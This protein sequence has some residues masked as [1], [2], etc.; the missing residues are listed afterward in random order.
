MRSLA[1]RVRRFSG[2]NPAA[3]IVSHANAVGAA[4]YLAEHLTRLFGIS[5]IPIVDA[6]IVL[7]A[8]VGPGSVAVSVRR[9]ARPLSVGAR[10]E[11]PHAMQTP[12]AHPGS[13]R[14]GGFLRR[15]RG[16][17]RVARKSMRLPAR[18]GR[19]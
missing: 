11:T 18:A 15:A 16:L 13:R 12:A 14:P 8:H 6:S 9:A 4:E 3:L 2:P 5:D 19:G 10:M 1:R 7:A 17:A